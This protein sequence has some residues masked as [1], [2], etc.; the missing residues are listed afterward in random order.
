[1]SSVH[2]GMCEYVLLYIIVMYGYMV[3]ITLHLLLLS[4]VT[5]M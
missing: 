3:N 2:L 5:I 4:V 1:M